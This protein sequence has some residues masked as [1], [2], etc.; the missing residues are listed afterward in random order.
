MIIWAAKTEVDSEDK[1]LKPSSIR[2]NGKFERTSGI[3]YDEL[4]PSV[5]EG[6]PPIILIHG[7]VHSGSC[8]ITTADGRP[9]WAFVFASKGYDV[10]GVCAA[11]RNWVGERLTSNA[12]V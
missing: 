2:V 9:G 4:K 10:L 1:L 3:Y 6:K 11:D 12:Y 7:G 8:Y 5:A